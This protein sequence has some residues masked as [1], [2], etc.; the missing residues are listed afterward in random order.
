MGSASEELWTVLR[1][2]YGVDKPPGDAIP[3]AVFGDES[4]IFATK[5]YLAVN[6]MAETS[7]YHKDSKA[8]RF[9]VCLIPFTSYYIRNKVNY[10]IQHMMKYVVDSCISLTENGALQGQVR[11]VVSSLK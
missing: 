3:I 8:S 9:L 2:Q 6:W 4:N 5:S 10:T 7:P 1:E 11:A